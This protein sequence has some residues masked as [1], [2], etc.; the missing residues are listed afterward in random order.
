MSL[1]DNLS[2][3]RLLS[4]LLEEVGTLVSKEVDL[5]K[6][7]LTQRVSVLAENAVAVFIA[8]A[9]LYAG[10]LILL[11]S[12]I[13][14]LATVVPMWLSALIVGGAVALS[15]MVAT[16]RALRRWKKINPEPEPLANG[17]FTAGEQR[18]AQKRKRKD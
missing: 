1:F 10:A 12:A 17:R 8:A 14:G 15:G 18:V 13:F 5:A 2:I 11:A 3:S 9:V 4:Q 16:L 6:S 7:E